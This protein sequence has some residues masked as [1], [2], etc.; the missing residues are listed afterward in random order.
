MTVT[1][2][3]YLIGRGVVVVVAIPVVD[4]EVVF[5]HE[6]E[7]AEHAATLL[8]LQQGNHPIGFGWVSSQAFD[9]ISPVAIIRAFMPPHFNMPFD[10][11]IRILGEGSFPV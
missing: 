4:F 9:P 8:S 5:C 6:A 2:E 1:V 7:S 11:R 3:Q 10:R